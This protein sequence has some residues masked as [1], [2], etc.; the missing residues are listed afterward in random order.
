MLIMEHFDRAARRFPDRPFVVSADGDLTHREMAAHVSAIANA[1]ARQGLGAGTNIAVLTPNHPLG[2][3]CNY[4]ILKA[5]CVWVPCNHRNP[6]RDTVVQVTA[7]DVRWLFYHSSLEEHAVAIQKSVPALRGMTPIDRATVSGVGLLEWTRGFAPGAPLPE[8]G[9]DDA[10]AIIS[11]GGTTGVPKGAVHTNRSYGANMANYWA[12]F[13][14]MSAPPVHLVVAPLTHAAG[15]MHMAMMGTGATHVLSPS[16]DPEM[17]LELVQRHRVTLMFLPPTIIYMLLAHPRLKQYD[18]SSLR[19]FLFGAAPMSVEKLREAIEHFG[20][21]LCHLYGS[22]ET[23]VMNTILPPEEMA[24]V[25]VTPAHARRIASCGREGPFSRVE[26]IDEDGTVL[27]PNERGEIAVRGEFLMAGY[28]KEPEKTTASRTNGWH[29]MGDIGLKDEDGY[30]YIVDRKGD[31]IITGGFNV[32][33]GEV[34]Q[35]V[36]ANPAV[37][38]CVVVGIPHE[39]WGEAILAAVE[40]KA[41]CHLD[42]EELIAQCKAQLGSVK[43]PKF[44]HVVEQLPRSPVGKTLRR[45]VRAPYWEGRSTLI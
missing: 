16:A 14:F 36:L 5:G 10:A 34:E 27:P 42:T 37:Q 41:G 32:F 35:A 26:I 28:Y 33:P 17:L 8:R 6:I 43:A 15:V 45:A 2:M 22:T 40:V 13:D 21:I 20:P 25:L 31:M 9:M 12:A 23:L 29:R 44:V 38:D 4:A 7:Q 30:I 19:H 11:S 24:D 3:A 39:K 18:C 1:I